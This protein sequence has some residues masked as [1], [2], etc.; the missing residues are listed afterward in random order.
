MKYDELL[1]TEPPHLFVQ[2]VFE[3][4]TPAQEYDALQMSHHISHRQLVFEPVTL[5]QHYMM[6]ANEPLHLFVQLVF[7][8]VTLVQ[9]HYVLL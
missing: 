3:P 4:V 8:P 1:M 9:P 6:R 2:L 5:D 7:E